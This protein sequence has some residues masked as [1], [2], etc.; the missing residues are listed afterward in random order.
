MI[1][2]KEGILKYSW[3]NLELSRTYV[4]ITLAYFFGLPNLLI[5]CVINHLPVFILK[6]YI[7]A[8]LIFQH[9]RTFLDKSDIFISLPI[10]NIQTTPYFSIQT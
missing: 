1:W 3:R 9:S 8:L 10:R 2:E 4:M 6:L 5:L 7:E